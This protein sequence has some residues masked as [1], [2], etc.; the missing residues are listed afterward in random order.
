MMTFSQT[1]ERVSGRGGTRRALPVTIIAAMA[2]FGVCEATAQDS[3]LLR[4]EL[5]T[6]GQPPLTL[7]TSSYLYQE[8]EPPKVLKLH[9][10]VTIVVNINSRVFSEGEVQN[11]KRAQLDAVLGDWIKFADG[12]LIPDPQSRGDPRISGKWNTQYR[13][14]A[15]LE[16]RDSLSF[17]IAAKVVDIRPNGNLVVEARQTV[18]NNDELWEQSLTGVI[19]REDVTP[20]NKVE[21]EDVAELRIM[22][23]ESGQVRDAYRRGWF[24][25]FFEKLSPI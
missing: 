19:R 10:I 15:D 22:K 11:R 25:K 1:T 16:T 13:A 2:A 20:D 14:E 9:D 17:T 18:Q 7:E 3:S 21:S 24:L 8:P 4:R 12:D 6:G 23:R 5:P